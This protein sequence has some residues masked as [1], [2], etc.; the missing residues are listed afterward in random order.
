MGRRI[1]IQ[2]DHVAQFG[3]KRRI[4][5]QLEAPHPVRL[6]AVRGPDALHRT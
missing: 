6:Q 4:L 1:E 5:R 3:G 2:A